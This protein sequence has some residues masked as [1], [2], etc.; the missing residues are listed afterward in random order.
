MSAM[1]TG[2]ESD[3][4]YVD[5]SDVE[6]REQMNE[7]GIIPQTPQWRARTPPRKRIKLKHDFSSPLSALRP[8]T[9]T[10]LLSQPM[11]LSDHPSSQSSYS[12]RHM[13]LSD[14]NAS[15]IS[16]PR[17]S[18]PS[19]PPDTSDFGIC[20]DPSE[21]GSGVQL[22]IPPMA[23]HGDIDGVEMEEMADIPVDE[24]S[25]DPLN[26]LQGSNHVGPPS[27]PTSLYGAVYSEYPIVEPQDN[28]PAVLDTPAMLSPP[29]TPN[30]SQ[31]FNLFTPDRSRASNSHRSVSP[32]Q[33]SGGGR[34]SASP[35]IPLQVQRRDESHS[36]IPL[37]LDN[38]VSP[39]STPPVLQIWPP[40]SHQHVTSPHV[41]DSGA[42]QYSPSVDIAG[43]AFDDPVNEEADAGQWKRYSMR[44][45]KAR[46]INPY[47]FDK[48]QYKLQLRH[49]PEA[50]VKVVS[51]QRRQVSH[52]DRGDDWVARDDEEDESQVEK[53]RRNRTSRER[54]VSIN[55][56][57]EAAGPED[58]QAQKWYPSAF[59][60]SD[61]E[62]PPLPKAKKRSKNSDGGQQEVGRR[63]P[64]KHSPSP[65][66]DF[67]QK[68][69]TSTGPATSKVH[70]RRLS[71]PQLLLRPSPSPTR[72][73]TTPTFKSRTHVSGRLRQLDRDSSPNI[74]NSADMEDG[75]NSAQL[76]D[77][78]ESLF[79]DDGNEFASEDMNSLRGSPDG[80]ESSGSRGTSKSAKGSPRPRRNKEEERQERKRW[81]ALHRMMPAVMV[82]KLLKGGSGK[83]K[84]GVR[85]PSPSEDEDDSEPVLLP[86]RSAITKNSGGHLQRPPP[87]K[88]DSESSDESRSSGE[89][90]SDPGSVSEASSG[91]NLNG[92][93]DGG[94]EAIEASFVHRS[95]CHSEA[96]RIVREHDM[97]D[98]MLS[99]TIGG[100]SRRS[101]KSLKRSKDHTSRSSRPQKKKPLDIVVRSSRSR[102]GRQTRLPFA[103]RED[104]LE[105]VGQQT[106]D[107]EMGAMEIDDLTPEASG[108]V[109]LRSANLN[110]FPTCSRKQ[111]KKQKRAEILRKQTYILPSGGKVITSGRRRN[112]LSI[113]VDDDGFH[114]ALAPL[115]SVGNTVHERRPVVK[116]NIVSRS[117]GLNNQPVSNQR[118]LQT[119][120]GL[121]CTVQPA[122]RQPGSTSEISP[123]SSASHRWEGPGVLNQIAK[124]SFD[125]DVPR[126]SA[127]LA[128]GPNTYL[129]RQFLYELLVSLAENA[130]AKEPHSVLLFDINLGT[131]TTAADF[132]DILRRVRELLSTWLHSAEFKCDD[133]PTFKKYEDIMVAVCHVAS[134]LEFNG[135]EEV[136]KSLQHAI[137]EEVQHLVYLIHRH[138]ESAT[139]G[140]DSM[141]V[142]SLCIGWFAFE[143]SSRNACASK[144]RGVNYDEKQW[145]SCAKL[146]IRFLLA[147]GLRQAVSP[148]HEK[149]FS[150]DPCRL[151]AAEIWICLIHVMPIL[152]PLAEL[153]RVSHP[154]WTVLLD[155]VE[156]H[157]LKHSSDFET[158][159]HMWRIIFTI[160]ALSQFSIHGTSSPAPKLP[161]CWEL[162]T[163]AL[164]V[165][166]LS[167]EPEVDH[168]LS[169]RSLRK[170][171][172][173]VRLVIARC[174][175]LSTR[176]HW[177]MDQA[178]AM[179][180]CLVEIF[181]SRKF[182]DLLGEF[183]EFPEFLRKPNLQLLSIQHRSDSA[184]TTF[185]KLV[186]QA[187]KDNSE[188]QTADNRS[189][190]KLKKLLSL[191]VPLSSVPFT[192]ATPPTDQALSML[193]NRFSSNIIA[194]YLDPTPSN[195]TSRLAQMRRYVSFQDADEKSRQA[196]IR[197]LLHTAMLVRHLS[198]PLDEP[199]LWL[200]DMT[201][202]LLSEY[203]PN[204]TGSAAPFPRRTIQAGA[205]LG[206][207]IV[208][209]QLLLGCV[210]RI[211]ATPS[212]IQSTT[213]EPTYPDPALL[214]GPWLISILSKKELTDEPTTR[215]E[216]FKLVQTVVNARE[217]F[218][219]VLPR[220][221]IASAT[222][223]ES[224]ES[225]DEFAPFN[226]DMNDPELIAAL[227]IDSSCTNIDRSKVMDE[228]MAEIM[229]IHF[230]PT[231]YRLLIKH[232]SDPTVKQHIKDRSDEHFYDVDKWVDCWFGCA[233]TIVQNRRTDWSRFFD[234]G[235]NSWERIGDSCL[236]RRVGFRFMFKLLQYDTS[237]YQKFQ[238]TFLSVFLESMV[239]ARVSLEH[240]YVSLLLSIDSLR[241]PMLCNLPVKR[242]APNQEF[243]LTK[244][245]FIDLR[246]SILEGI[247]TNISY[248]LARTDYVE[249]TIRRHIQEWIGFIQNALTA[250]QESSQEHQHANYTEFIRA[251][252]ARLSRYPLLQ[253]Q[254]RLA[255]MVAWGASLEEGGD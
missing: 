6:E 103:V 131:N 155:V 42:A 50:I 79:D 205:G 235:Q 180:N 185:L 196:C 120:L 111:S 179:F 97:I 133:L 73:A 247:F 251:V 101:R 125:L 203:G 248:H 92:E 52:H 66:P 9:S 250:M 124:L 146:L 241:H 119:H 252:F 18:S 76:P 10:P 104:S 108:D 162:V 46:Q 86:G 28:L 24:G 57:D 64:R 65:A 156:E 82:S 160:T 170:R 74:E 183:P 137:S 23:G 49:V 45:R 200:N 123:N 4:D 217:K 1:D 246:L 157:V 27:P 161:C 118:L 192:K 145:L 174:Y 22:C 80:N 14:A 56:G 229:D 117:R 37:H 225:Q 139:E 254:P 129:G 71:D 167:A 220:T 240:E 58:G 190:T 130:Q 77:S 243:E 219:P 207:A 121:D 213:V 116:R 7:M 150:E 171:D 36:E 81:K 3:D 201:M 253:S 107:Q 175:L 218:M 166:R 100:V 195:L 70:R 106:H 84:T 110:E 85:A 209:I 68:K 176:W 91:G 231:I 182:A 214:S 44:P 216:I 135:E 187:A 5:T 184:F 210:R 233:A 102:G 75:R 38:T 12:E 83:T 136:R 228:K 188:G 234:L 236:R 202:L 204:E 194:I 15:E 128:F 40:P 39:P 163:A 72:I 198:L 32:P 215:K 112:V 212:M 16:L 242:N 2:V 245:E 21:D 8:Q 93:S 154:F 149:P 227:E 51:P 237:S 169:P 109:E 230:S 35:P 13:A 126:F 222:E 226:L 164:R 47:E 151:R 90:D 158:S 249:D 140:C 43:P 173:Y 122:I 142:R 232:F 181:K 30:L 208:C 61:D 238:H 105:R 197:A 48:R 134:W 172:E 113:N 114:R 148:L 78:M 54:D 19:T 69:N 26:F 168:H 60:L 29:S 224:Q 143:L 177:R 94:D 95:N 31:S 63:E 89:D 186:V 239:T 17:S 255:K 193:Y 33:V 159:E 221:S 59:D 223:S 11:K 88:G 138:G 62:L 189:A 115:R 132:I 55:E 99:R 144:R 96:P 34:G 152:S 67:H 147:H 98:R 25:Q 87:V 41:S 20:K 199:L 165:I 178:F 53:P 153:A 191:A 244:S 206:H 211:I 141:D 127:G